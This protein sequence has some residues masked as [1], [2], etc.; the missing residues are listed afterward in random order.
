MT[1]ARTTGLLLFVLAAPPSAF[2][3][4]PAALGV[5]SPAFADN[6]PIPVDYT[7]DGSQVPPPIEW[8]PVPEGTRSIAILI[9]DPDAPRETFTHW[10]VTGISPRVTSLE[11][12]LPPGAIVGE[13]DR[14]FTNY[15]GP[16][17]PAG[18]HYYRFIVY[19]LDITPQSTR[20]AA[21]LREI[22]GHVLATGR[23]VGSYE[24]PAR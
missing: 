22:D 23:L 14:G 7:C 19:A 20:R 9:D 1:P 4:P 17:P 24:R 5:T 16:C 21:F 18:R 10:L 8:S 2:G 3:A 13:N 12:E 11:G 6:D 15:T